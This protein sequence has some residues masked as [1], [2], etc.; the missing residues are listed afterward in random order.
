MT[1]L[2]AIVL[3]ICGALLNS[4]VHARSARCEGCDLAQYR[5]AALA[6]GPG[7]HVISSFSTN[8][9]RGYEVWVHE[10]PGFSTLRVKPWTVPAEYWD[11]FAEARR[12]YL[13]APS[14]SK[15]IHV[16]GGDLG[17]EGLTGAT[18]YDIMGDANLRGRLGDRLVQP[19]PGVDAIIDRALAG[20]AAGAYGHL[21]ISDATIFIVVVT[22]DGSTV[23]YEVK[24]GSMNGQYLEGESRTSGGQVIP[25]DDTED[26]EGT[27]YGEAEDLGAFR[28]H[29]LGIGANLTEP[30]A[31]YNGYYIHSVTCT[32][33]GDATQLSCHV[34]W[35][36]I[37]F[38]IP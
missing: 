25:E 12:F 27:W 24:L 15:V 4:Q 33:D 23:S 29:L 30:Y 31:N 14:F 35:R 5:Q 18:A 19:L 8:E 3:L 28:T 16:N 13:I 21:G 38:S 2:I 1:R 36:P 37:P 20:I 6:L 22:Y 32:W 7:K 9:L 10:E 17:V 26:W 34:D 11:L